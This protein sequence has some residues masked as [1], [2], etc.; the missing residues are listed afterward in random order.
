[1]KQER[2]RAQ[3]PMQAFQSLLRWTFRPSPSA[4]L[5]LVLLAGCGGE[6]FPMVKAS[7]KITYEDGTLLPAQDN[8][9]RLTFLPQ[10]PPLDAK[11]HRRPGIA[12]VNLDDGTFECVTTHR[13]GDG[14]IRGKHKVVISTLVRQQA[15]EG[16]P[17]E[18]NDPEKTPLE[19]DTANLPFHLKIRKP[20]S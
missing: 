7:G 15:P 17:P 19:V 11:T 20:S 4:L 18:Y 1:M 10:T 14:L 8:L 9:V 5:I 2:R 3:I 6:P 13:Y 16:V 12:D